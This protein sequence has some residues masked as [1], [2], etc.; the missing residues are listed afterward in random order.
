MSRGPFLKKLNISGYKLCFGHCLAQADHLVPSLELTAL[1]EKLNTL[2][3]L[4]NVAFGRNST[5]PFETAMLGHK[6][7]S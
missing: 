6:M 3:A 1:L 4:E 7:M 5:G 2:E